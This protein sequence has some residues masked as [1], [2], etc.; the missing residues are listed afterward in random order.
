MPV[1]Q[2][3]APGKTERSTISP[4]VP[5]SHPEGSLCLGSSWAWTTLNVRSRQGDWRMAECQ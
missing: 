2:I 3:V 1:S 5:Y 4:E